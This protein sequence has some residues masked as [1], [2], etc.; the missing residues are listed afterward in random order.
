MIAENERERQSANQS[1]DTFAEIVRT[2]IALIDSKLEK[3][4][5]AYLESAL[6]LDEYRV[7][8][9][10]LI[11]SKQLLKEKL[12]AFEQKSNN[13]F[14]LTDKFLKACIDNAKIAFDG[15]ND[16]SIVAFRKVGSN[17]QI[18]NRTVNFEPR[19][20]WKIL[21]ESGLSGGNAGMS[22][23]SA[24]QKG[25]SEMDFGKLRRRWDSNPRYL[26][27]R[28]ISSALH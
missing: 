10:T 17:F 22:A 16:E 27:V 7:A 12:S 24:D 4:M 5:N 15:T 28:R 6:T 25:R 2:D 18:K 20:A 9:S 21:S 23:R 1:S 8:K 13:R 3:L 19:S 11:A 14:E 26:A